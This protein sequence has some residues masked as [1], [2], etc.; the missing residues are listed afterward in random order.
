[1]GSPT[2]C[3]THGNYPTNISCINN[4]D[5]GLAANPRKKKSLESLKL[6]HDWSAQNYDLFALQT[7][8][9]GQFQLRFSHNVLEHQRHVGENI[10]P[11]LLFSTLCICQ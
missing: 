7:V 10:L 5:C 8:A 3:L 4:T 11:F 1:M 6:K 9:A 2:Q